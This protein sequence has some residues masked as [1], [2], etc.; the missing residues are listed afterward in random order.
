M[1]VRDYKNMIHYIK[2][3]SFNTRYLILNPLLFWYITSAH[4]GRL[5]ERTQYNESNLVM[6]RFEIHDY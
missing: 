1:A 2:I 6:N 4:S 3:E 5:V